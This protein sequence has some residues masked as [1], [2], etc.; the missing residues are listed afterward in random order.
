MSKTTT[1]DFQK[2]MFIE[3]KEEGLSQD[4]KKF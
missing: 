4:G 2:G 1:A 3:F